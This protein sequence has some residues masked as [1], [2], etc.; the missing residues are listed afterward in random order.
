[1]V[2]GNPAQN[3]DDIANV[4]HVF[5]GGKRVFGMSDRPQVLV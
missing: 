5:L 4:Q 1:L 2:E 3:I